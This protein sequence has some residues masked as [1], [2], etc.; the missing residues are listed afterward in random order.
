MRIISIQKKNLIPGAIYEAS[1]VLRGGGSVVFPT[2][3]LYALGANATSGEAVARLFRIKSRPED[4]AVPIFV[5]NLAMLKKYAYVD[6]GKDK[7]LGR[8]WPG[9]VTVVLYKKFSLPS[10]LTG[11]KNTVG[12]RIPDHSLARLLVKSV[13]FPITATSANVSGN[14]PSRK[15]ADLLR[16]FEARRISPDLVLD[17]GDLPES[18]PS[19]VLDL[20]QEEPKVLRAGPVTTHALHEILNS[21]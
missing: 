7:I 2:D 21:S 10:I 18:K 1:R 8:V 20:T 14:A 15:I 19:T 5:Q 6:Y 11:G 9:Q 3:T 12:V 17:A 4:R 13:G 16:E